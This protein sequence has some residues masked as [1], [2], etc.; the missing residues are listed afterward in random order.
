MVYIID[1]AKIISDIGSKTRSLL[2]KNNVIREMKKEL[3][4]FKC[5]RM[6]ASSLW[7]SPAHVMVDLHFPLVAPD[8]IKKNYFT[9]HFLQHGCSTLITACKINF[10]FQL[11]TQLK[12][13]RE[14]L[15]NSPIDYVIGVQVPIEKLSVALIHLIKKNKI[16]LIFVS[17]KSINQIVNIAWAWIKQALF[18]NQPLFVPILHPTFKGDRTEVL[19]IWRDKL[20]NNNI[21][22]MSDEI[23]EKTPLSMEEI[24]KIGLY[25]KRGNIHVGGEVSYNLYLPSNNIDDQCNIS[26]DKLNLAVM[27]MRG[28]IIKIRN[29]VN[30]IP[31]FGRNLFIKRPSLFV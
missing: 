24:K 11:D 31:G 17:I 8:S 1:K 29:E 4:Q 9:T 21:P 28:Q 6:N 3:P 30:F 19:Q 25:P 18:P 20:T 16:P 7:M 5:I 13:M 22:H 15:M 26:Y 2:V 14:E 12:K 23:K 27:V 10:P